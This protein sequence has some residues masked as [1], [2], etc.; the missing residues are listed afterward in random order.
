M[1]QGIRI[2]GVVVIELIFMAFNAFIMVWNCC[3]CLN[4]CSLL[5]CDKRK[6]NIYN[7][8]E[9]ILCLKNLC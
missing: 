2:I 6:T 8:S 9:E 1:K 7:L 3:N 4:E 5:N